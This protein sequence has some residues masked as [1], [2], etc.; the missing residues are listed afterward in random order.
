MAE[1]SGTGRS[2]ATWHQSLL[3]QQ[4]TRKKTN[5]QK[6]Q[7]TTPNVK[8]SIFRVTGAG[9]LLHCIDSNILQAKYNCYHVIPALGA[10]ANVQY[11]KI[12]LKNNIQSQIL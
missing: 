2:T 10:D 7:A 5:K 12:W 6:G 11:N 9:Q 4:S 8:M 3:R 1:S